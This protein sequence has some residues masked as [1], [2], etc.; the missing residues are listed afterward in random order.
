MSTLRRFRDP[1]V[2]T[3]IVNIGGSVAFDICGNFNDDERYPAIP[4]KVTNQVV[5]IETSSE[6]LGASRAELVQEF[7][8]CPYDED[9]GFTSGLTV[10]DDEVDISYIIQGGYYVINDI[11]DNLKT[12]I[13]NSL[14]NVRRDIS[15]YTEVVDEGSIAIKGNC[16]MGACREVDARYSLTGLLY[17]VTDEPPSDNY[18]FGN[19]NNN[20]GRNYFFRT[21]LYVKYTS[22]GVEKIVCFHSMVND[23]D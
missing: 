18:V 9:N 1:K 3:K 21:P 6:V 19:A 17:T 2:E 8:Q 22:N 20:F 23:R 14:A 13:E 15:G 11:G 5:D 7:I 12:F 10:I 4:W 16:V